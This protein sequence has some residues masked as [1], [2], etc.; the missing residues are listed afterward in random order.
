MKDKFRENVKIAAPPPCAGD[1][2]LSA[3]GSTGAAPAPAAEVRDLLKA[4][5]I[6]SSW[7]WRCRA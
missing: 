5:P 2:A 4:A 1:P 3:A 7:C 6:C